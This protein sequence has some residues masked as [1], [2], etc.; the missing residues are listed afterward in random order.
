MALTI[1][2]IFESLMS[3]PKTTVIMIA[4]HYNTPYIT[5]TTGMIKHEALI[6]LSPTEI[7]ENYH[8]E[9]WWEYIYEATR[10]YISPDTPIFYMKNGI[11]SDSSLKTIN[12]FINERNPLNKV[13]FDLKNFEEEYCEFK[14]Y[15]GNGKTEIY[16]IDKLAEI[17]AEYVIKTEVVHPYTVE[18]FS[19]VLYD[20]LDKW[21][22]T[23]IDP[24]TH[25]TGR[26]QKERY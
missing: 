11:N 14:E 12:I 19:D 3:F 20:K 1:K 15:G 26:Y 9:N 16:Y 10:H 6:S 5:K 13:A 4:V 18:Y 7:A 17:L 23:L 25:N 2:T 22:T 24:P 21:R 8:N